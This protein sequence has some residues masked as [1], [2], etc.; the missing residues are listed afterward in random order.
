VETHQFFQ[1]L[2]QTVVVEAV[3]Q[4]MAMVQQVDQV[5]GVDLLLVEHHLEQ[6]VA[7]Q[8]IHLPLVHLKDNL[9]ELV[10]MLMVVQQVVVEQVQQVVVEILLLLKEEIIMVALVVMV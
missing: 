2:H 5:E 7:E 1:Q 4:I 8:V 10:E 3:V 6:D 9:V